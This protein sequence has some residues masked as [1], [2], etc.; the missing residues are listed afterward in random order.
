VREFQNVRFPDPLVLKYLAGAGAR[1]GVVDWH[2]ERDFR[3]L[4]T[5]RGKDRHYTARAGLI[6]DRSSIP[7]W[8]QSIVQKD[9]P[10]VRA[11]VI[12][13]DLYENKPE[14]WTRKDADWLLYYGCRASGTPWLEANG[15]YYAVRIGGQRA[16][17]T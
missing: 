17:D 8:A 5:D 6:T 15:M 4:W 12:H 9:G 2:L 14:G 10:K 16:W 3:V 13:D 11:S 1:H 7:G